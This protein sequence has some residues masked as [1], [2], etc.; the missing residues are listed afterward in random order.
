MGSRLSGALGLMVVVLG[1]GPARGA[2]IVD[3]VTVVKKDAIAVSFRMTEAFGEEVERAVASGL[4]V[5]FHFTVELKKVRTLWINRKVAARHVRTTV[6]YDNLTE[7]YKLS[8]EI[9]GEMDATGVVSDPEAMRRFMVSFESTELF[10]ASLLEPNEEY[11][12]RVKGLVRE[13]NLF[14]F[15]PWDVGAGWKRAHFTYLP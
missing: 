2:E 4:P 12:V 10:P 6:V 7:R 13:R 8:R 1:G 11:Y 14:L 9:D 5:S 3:L 15:I